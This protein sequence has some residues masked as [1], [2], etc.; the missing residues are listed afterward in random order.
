MKRFK[1]GDKVRVIEQSPYAVYSLP[2]YNTY[3]VKDV[4][5][6]G[7]IKLSNNLELYYSSDRFE[8]LLPEFKTLKIL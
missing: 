3:I 7:A 6:F 2:L 1:I 8:L 5:S 4:G